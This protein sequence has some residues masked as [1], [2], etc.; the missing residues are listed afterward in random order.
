MG[1]EWVDRLAQVLTNM[2][3]VRDQDAATVRAQLTA[4]RQEHREILAEIRA[5][6]ASIAVLKEEI[7]LRGKR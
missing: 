1:A 6:A 7:L 3:S 5:H 4:L 2:E